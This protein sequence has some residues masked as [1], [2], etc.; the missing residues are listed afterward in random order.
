MAAVAADPH[1]VAVAGE[2]DALLDVLEQTAVALLVMAL[3]GGH[4]TEFAGYL[5]EAFF[6][7][8]G[9]H[10]VV[11][12][13]PLV[14]LALGGIAE[15]GHR[16]GDVA[17]VEKLEPELGVF[18]L[19]VGR[20]LEYCGYL[21]VAVAA[22]LR[23]VVA[24]FVSCL[25]FAGERLHQVAFCFRSFKFFH[26]F[27]FMFVDVLLFIHTGQSPRNVTSTASI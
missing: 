14:V 18:L 22:C 20:F 24:V 23:G 2:H 27:V 1:S 13:G 12:V 25:R 19:V 15:V 26:C 7:G 8:F 3:D 16:V 4:G 21:L 11:H 9:R 5:G 17:A 6:L 10:A